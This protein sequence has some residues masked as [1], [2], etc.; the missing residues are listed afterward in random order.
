MTTRLQHLVHRTGDV[1]IATDLGVPRSTARGWLGGAPTAVV[2]LDVADLTEPE[3]RQEVV[4][5]RRRVQKLTA[6][7]RL[8]L[9]VLRTSGFR[10]T[11]ERLP[12]GRDKM[13]ILRTV[14]RARAF[15][16][17]ACPCPTPSACAIF[18]DMSN[19]ASSAFS[20]PA[21]LNTIT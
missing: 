21:S 7:L 6:L 15:V 20:G 14:D 12:D 11:D 9:A 4:K 5:L 19:S 8:V 13:R 1:T 3:L 16:Q 2:C 10:L 18:R 17:L